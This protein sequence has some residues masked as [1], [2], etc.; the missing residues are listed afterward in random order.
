[1]AGDVDEEVVFPRAA[2]V[3][4]RL[5]LG[6]VYAALGQRHEHLEQGAGVGAGFV[7]EE[8]EEAGHVAATADGA[9]GLFAEDEEAGGVVGLVLDVTGLDGD[10]VVLGRE[11]VGEGG[12]AGLL[13]GDL[14]GACGAGGLDELGV[15]HVAGEPLAALREGLV[16]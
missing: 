16:F 4:A 6:E 2:L 7:A 10:A 11:L 5:D 12:G 13:L 8:D 9:A 1:M 15:R 14:D 3:G